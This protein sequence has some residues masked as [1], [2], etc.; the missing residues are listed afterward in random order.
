MVSGGG[1]IVE[2]SP[3]W[4]ERRKTASYVSPKAVRRGR[5]VYVTERNVVFKAGLNGKV[6]R[7]FRLPSVPDS[8]SVY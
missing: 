1:G 7:Q 4:E 3:E 2:F 6:I 5:F 8:V